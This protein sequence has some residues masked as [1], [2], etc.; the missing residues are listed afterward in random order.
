MMDSDRKKWN[1]KYRER[2]D[3]LSSP[4]NFIEGEVERLVGTTVLDVACGDGGNAL[5]L[6][7]QGELVGMS[8]ALE[9]VERTEYGGR[10]QY[11]EGYVFRRR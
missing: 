6:A 9:C 4:E 8:E 7:E 1:A 11:L 5:F 10:E 3:D 2:S